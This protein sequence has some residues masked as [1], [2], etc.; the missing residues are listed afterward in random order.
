MAGEE[1]LPCPERLERPLRIDGEN[2]AAVPARGL[3]AGRNREGASCTGSR[4]RP[5]SCR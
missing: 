1:A 5:P 3:M 4:Y 2:D